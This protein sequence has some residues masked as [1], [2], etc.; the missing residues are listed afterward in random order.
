MKAGAFVAQQLSVSV[1]G[2]QQLPRRNLDQRGC[3]LVFWVYLIYGKRERE[4]SEFVLQKDGKVE[5]HHPG[6]PAIF[7]FP[8]LLLQ[9]SCTWR[10]SGF[11]L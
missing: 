7:I 1:G 6:T 10:I 3:F 5:A 8:L 2:V 9:M 11:R 4:A